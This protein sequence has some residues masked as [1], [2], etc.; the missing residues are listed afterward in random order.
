MEPPKTIPV[1]VN[2]FAIVDAE[3][4]PR[5]SRWK[6]Q[7]KGRG[8]ACRSAKVNG[9][10]AHISMHREVIGDIGNLQADHRNGN[11]LDNR[12]ANLR[13]A[14]HSQNQM[15]KGVQVNNKSGQRGVYFNKRRQQW[16]AQICLNGVRKFLG[17]HPSLE[18]ASKAYTEA[19]KVLHGEFR[20]ITTNH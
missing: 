3:D 17:A 14:T 13:P 8:Y 10:Q 20:R 18:K 12:K 1:G 2:H 9:K 16:Y 7:L 6:W 11:R 5:L 4:H 19:A 15:N